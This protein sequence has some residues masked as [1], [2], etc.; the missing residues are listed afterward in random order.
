MFFCLLYYTGTSSR[1]EFARGCYRYGYYSKCS[2]L[3]EQISKDP[4][5]AQSEMNQALLLLG[6]ANFHLY[7]KMHFEIQKE[8]RLQQYY[9]A[10]YQAKHR[11]CYEK[12]KIVIGKL[13]LPWMGI[14]WR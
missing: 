1:L 13:G 10:S 4:T 8:K 12:A 3:C 6:K 11:Q 7:R 9:T 5:I 14:S 2:E